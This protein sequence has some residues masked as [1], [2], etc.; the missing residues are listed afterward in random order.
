MV[1]K[2]GPW[3]PGLLQS[4]GKKDTPPSYVWFG[5]AEKAHD[6]REL[7]N[8]E[9][10][11]V[12]CIREGFPDEK[13]GR[14]RRGEHSQWEGRKGRRGCIVPEEPQEGLQSRGTANRGKRAPPRKEAGEVGRG[15]TEQSFI[16]DT[17][18]I[19]NGLGD[20][21]CVWTLETTSQATAAV[22]VKSDGCLDERGGTG[23]RDVRG[24][25]GYLRCRINTTRRLRDVRSVR[26][27]QVKDDS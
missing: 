4:S 18:R 12:W 5:H 9:S 23:N 14:V 7:F 6:S 2:L 24:F 11:L 16:K 21:E 26:E 27:R 8:K 10:K 25:K 19:R 22:W 20:G 15:R 17:G 1:I 3:P 13:C